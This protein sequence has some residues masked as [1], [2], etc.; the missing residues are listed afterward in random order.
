MSMAFREWERPAA[1]EPR[2]AATEAQLKNVC[3]RHS[4]L[5]L[6]ENF[7]LPPPPLG[8]PRRLLRRAR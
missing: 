4:F 2:A 3:G 8:R 5:D 1:Q 7:T 6:M